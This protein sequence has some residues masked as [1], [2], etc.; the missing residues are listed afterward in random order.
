MEYLQIKSYM[1]TDPQRIHGPLLFENVD[2]F[3]DCYTKHASIK[4]SLS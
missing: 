4:D 1:Y 3:I 2:W